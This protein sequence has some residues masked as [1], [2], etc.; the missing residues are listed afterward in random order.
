VSLPDD[1]FDG[2]S[3][4]WIDLR[5][6]NLESLPK[7][8]GSQDKLTYLYLQNNPLSEHSEYNWAAD[9][10]SARDV[11]KFMPEFQEAMGLEVTT[12]KPKTRQQIAEEELKKRQKK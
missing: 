2:L 7:S 6:N 8:I 1:I 5:S 3:L 11:K 4:D 10:H 12:K 9:F